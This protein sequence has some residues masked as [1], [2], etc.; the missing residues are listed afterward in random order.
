MNI[1]NIIIHFLH[2]PLLLL[3]EQAVKK[4]LLVNTLFISSFT[5]SY[6]PRAKEDF[7]R[8]TQLCILTLEHKLHC[9]GKYFFSFRMDQ[10]H[11][12]H[13]LQ[14][15]SSAIEAFLNTGNNEW[16]HYWVLFLLI[17]TDS[18]TFFTVFFDLI[19]A[20][21]FAQDCKKNEYLLLKNGAH[22]Q[23][24]TILV[25]VVTGSFEYCCLLEKSSLILAD[26]SG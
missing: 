6:S 16:L 17:C 24:N 20:S 19:V 7:K 18:N 2:I 13:P 21:A 1:P 26:N 5:W 4:G 12:W 11:W 25:S 3:R 9:K 23:L 22:L 15:F 14:L 10:F 8:F